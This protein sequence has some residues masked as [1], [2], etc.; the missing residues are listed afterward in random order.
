MRKQ[1]A[2]IPTQINK[3]E[4]GLT[5]L[6]DTNITVERLK[7]DLIKLLPEIERKTKEAQESVVVLEQQQEIA[8]A[9]EKKTE[10]DTKEARKKEAEVAAIKADCDRELAKAL[11]EL[12]KAL[13]ALDTLKP[14][15]I[16]EMR[17]YA[18]PPADIVLL[19]SAVQ[20]LM[21][22]KGAWP[23]AVQMMKDPKGFV[24]G[25]KTYDKDNIKQKKLDGL[26]KFI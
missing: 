12:D 25:L 15:D 9:E 23:E 10:G 3:Y 4:A 24:D 19:M 5:R 7:A 2:I 16:G 6:A 13:R 17:G 18:N 22:V 1:Q 8:T 26:K 14:S 11:P 20:F 21:D